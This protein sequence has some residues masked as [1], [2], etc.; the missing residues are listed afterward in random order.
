VPTLA[1]KDNVA[2]LSQTRLSLSDVDWMRMYSLSV[3]MLTMVAIIMTV[4][5]Y[6]RI[7]VDDQLRIS[8]NRDDR[9]I[10]QHDR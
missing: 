10:H 5:K 2:I 7:K 4:N 8:D 1:L 9:C 6:R 3:V